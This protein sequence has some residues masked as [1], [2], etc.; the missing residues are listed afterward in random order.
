MG[1]VKNWAY[2]EAEK[3]IDKIC[4][5]YREDKFTR[6]EAIYEL[7]QIENVYIYLGDDTTQDVAEELLDEAKGGVYA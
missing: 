6:E 4:I 1:K 7:M 5:A 3:Q 2:E